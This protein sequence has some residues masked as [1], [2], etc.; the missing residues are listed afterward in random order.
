MPVRSDKP[1]LELVK[2]SEAGTDAHQDF[3]AHLFRRYKDSLSRYL[4]QR[5]CTPEEADEILQEAYVRMLQAPE[6]EQLES[7]ARGY[8][9]KTATN[10]IHDRHR[11]NSARH[12]DRH[13][14]ISDAT[15]DTSS[16]TLE[17]TIETDQELD[18]VK[19]ALLNLQP[20]C[21]EI[22]LLYFVENLKQ[23]EIASIMD[24]STKT[25]ERELTLAL[26]YCK[27]Q[28]GDKQ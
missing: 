13:D 21:R 18:I 15:L 24:V 3:V 2:G 10:L 8:L 20:R 14:P 1:K 17:A 23:R 25:V 6:L 4:R 26:R 22:F 27:D 5:H 28:L 16:R 9:F 7:K 11:Y 12:F 19:A